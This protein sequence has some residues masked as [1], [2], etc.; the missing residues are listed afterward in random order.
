QRS[1]QLKKPLIH[2]VMAIKKAI[3]PTLPLLLYAIAR[4]PTSFSTKT[5][6]CDN[7]HDEQVDIINTH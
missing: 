6:H 2:S 5:V 7:P 1:D 3:R 4:L